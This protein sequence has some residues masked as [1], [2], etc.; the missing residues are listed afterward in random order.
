MHRASIHL[1]SIW[2]PQVTEAITKVD[3]ADRNIWSSAEYVHNLYD[4]GK[5]K[6][7]YLCPDKINHADVSRASG[8]SVRGEIEVRGANRSWEKGADGRAI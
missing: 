5:D 7:F 2:L 6:A 4:E 1:T 8:C 3:V